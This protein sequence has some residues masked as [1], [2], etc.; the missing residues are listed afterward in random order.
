MD[1]L[2][3]LITYKVF[4]CKLFLLLELFGESFMHFRLKQVIKDLAIFD[5]V[6]LVIVGIIYDLY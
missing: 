5:F 3:G 2:F 6:V 4:C 1:S